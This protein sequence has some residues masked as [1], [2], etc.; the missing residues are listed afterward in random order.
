ML[1]HF[2]VHSLRCRL[3]LIDRPKLRSLTIREAELRIMLVSD[4]PATFREE[5]YSRRT[6]CDGRRAEVRPSGLH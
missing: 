1:G 6:G 4:V 3:V 2:G 5:H